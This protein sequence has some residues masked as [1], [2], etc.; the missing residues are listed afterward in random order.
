M[1]TF[2]LK[3]GPLVLLS[4]RCVFYKLNTVCFNALILFRGL[5]FYTLN[6]KSKKKKKKK[7]NYRK[8]FHYVKLLMLV[9]CVW[10]S[11]AIHCVFSSEYPSLPILCGSMRLCEWSGSTKLEMSLISL[12]GG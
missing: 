7:R 11:F 1:N 10:H 6:V 5:I 3:A 8:A 4:R 12:H 9:S 2:F